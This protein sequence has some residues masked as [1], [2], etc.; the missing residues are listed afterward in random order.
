MENNIENITN[1]IVE[2]IQPE[3]ILYYETTYLHLFVVLW[4]VEMSSYDK[5]VYLRRILK[6][7][8]I[9]FDITTYTNEGF[10]RAVKEQIYPTFDI[11]KFGTTL[12]EKQYITT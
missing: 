3:K 8:N 12:Y 7:V 4:D 10:Q 2:V 5:H 1:I 6:T 11:A 9:P